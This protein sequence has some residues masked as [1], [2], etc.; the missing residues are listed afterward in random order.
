MRG[1]LC[2]KCGKELE[3]HYKP[4]YHNEYF[5][6]YFECKA[7]GFETEK[8]SYSYKGLMDSG[9]KLIS[10]YNLKRKEDEKRKD[11]CYSFGSGSFC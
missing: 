7:C 5:D 11:S 9:Y 1:Y 6:I 2:P 8:I 10:K 4:E 3:F